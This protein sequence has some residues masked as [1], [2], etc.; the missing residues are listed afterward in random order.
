M[1]NIEYNQLVD[2]SRLTSTTNNREIYDD[3]LDSVRCAIQPLDDS[4]NQDIVGSMGKDRLMF[5]AV[6]DIV[7]GDKVTFESKVYKVVAVENFNDFRRQEQHMEI[8]IREYLD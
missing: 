2:V 1:I 7:E 5:C 6:Q 8:L 4:F 3:H